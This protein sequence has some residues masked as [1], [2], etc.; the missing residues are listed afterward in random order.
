M[1]LP[2][3]LQRTAVL[4]KIFHAD[5]YFEAKGTVIY[6][7]PASGMGLVFRDIKPYCQSILQKWIL[8][9]LQNRSSGESCSG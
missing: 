2:R 5:D 7:R 3:L 9:T 4:V 1:L 8:S 6:V